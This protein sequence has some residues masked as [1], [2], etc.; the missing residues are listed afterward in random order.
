MKYIK[1]FESSD[2]KYGYH[3]TRRKNLKKIMEEGLVSKVPKDYGEE[4]DIEGVYL[5][6]TLEDVKSALAQWM[7]ERI[8]EWEEEY[9]EDYDEVLL[10]VDITDINY[11][12]IIVSVE[13]EWVVTTKID[14]SKISLADVDF[15]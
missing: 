9:D 14:P 6:K 11:L 12:D 3:I 15:I 7:G 2:K 10:K 1:L 4:G 8:E 13:Y 5:F